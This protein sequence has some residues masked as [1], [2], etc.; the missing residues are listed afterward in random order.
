MGLNP[1]VCLAVSKG[2]SVLCALIT[3]S[4]QRP[5]AAVFAGFVRRGC[6][7]IKGGI[8]PRDKRAIVAKSELHVWI[9]KVYDMIF[10]NLVK[11]STSFPLQTALKCNCPTS[12]MISVQ[13]C[14]IITKEPTLVND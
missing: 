5:V 2:L 14:Q 6:G 3:H 4:H 13:M 10:L 1:G 7:G 12:L 8:S 9:V 11:Y